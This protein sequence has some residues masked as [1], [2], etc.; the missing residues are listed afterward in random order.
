MTRNHNIQFTKK[1]SE[2]K[3]QALEIKVGA[4]IEA[5]FFRCQIK[6]NLTHS[7]SQ[8]VWHPFGTNSRQMGSK[9]FWRI[10]KGKRA[11][12]RICIV[13]SKNLKFNLN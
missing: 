7:F 2:Q 4:Q 12:K 9:I 1:N 11:G 5:L 8:I 13:L 10:L 3:I 6:K